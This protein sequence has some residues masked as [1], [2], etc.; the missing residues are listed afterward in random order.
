[1]EVVVGLPAVAQGGTLGARESLHLGVSVMVDDH[2]DQD[3]SQGGVV[4]VVV[5]DVHTDPEKDS[6]GEGVVLAAERGR[7]APVSSFVPCL[8]STCLN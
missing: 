6:A 2:V 8:D 7:G 5:A 4:V 1:M 3:K